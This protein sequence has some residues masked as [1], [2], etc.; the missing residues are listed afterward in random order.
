MGYLLLPSQLLPQEGWYINTYLEWHQKNFQ[1]DSAYL[2]NKHFWNPLPLL[3]GGYVGIFPARH[4]KIYSYG[5][6][7]LTTLIAFII[8]WK[9]GYDLFFRLAF[10]SENFLVFSLNKQFYGHEF[11]WHND[12]NHQTTCFG[13]LKNKPFNS[14]AKDI[15]STLML[16]L[17]SA[18]AEKKSHPNIIYVETA[19]RIE[20]WSAFNSRPYGN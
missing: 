9:E 20:I 13:E 4:W 8:K 18:G 2:E 10:S 5:L 16:V 19:K 11:V 7:I 14:G 17:Y 3:E 1:F 12:K 6:K 15:P